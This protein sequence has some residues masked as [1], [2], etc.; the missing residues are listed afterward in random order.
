M[1]DPETGILA[2]IVADSLIFPR[3]TT[4]QYMGRGQGGCVPLQ[5]GAM[6]EM[7]SPGT[8]LESFGHNWPIDLDSP[9]AM[10]PLISTASLVSVS[11]WE[12]ALEKLPSNSFVWKIL[13]ITLLFRRFWRDF[14][15]NSLK[16]GTWGGGGYDLIGHN[17]GPSVS[18]ARFEK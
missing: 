2:A 14:L 7:Q 16:T 3:V 11:K 17:S 12:L 8:H 1:G 9:F 13:R 6:F 4:V 15:S 5:V 18:P 10:T